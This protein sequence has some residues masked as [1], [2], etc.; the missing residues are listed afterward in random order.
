[1][2]TVRLRMSDK[3]Y[4]SAKGVGGDDNDPTHQALRS[5]SGMS[6]QGSRKQS[7]VRKPLPASDAA[8]RSDQ[9]SGD[10][11]VQTLYAALDHVDSG[12]LI[13][14]K[15]LRV[16]Y[17]NPALHETFGRDPNEINTKRP[18]YT[19]LLKRTAASLLVN[20]DDYVKRRLAWVRAADGTPMDLQMT[21]GKVVRAKVAL[22]PNG[23]RM[24]VYT[25]VTDIVRQAQELERLATTDGMT[26]IYNRR[27]FLTLADHEWNRARR[28]DRPV[29]F[30]MIDID[31]FKSVN[32]NFGHQVG[33]LMITHLANLAR[34]SKRDCD[35]LARI[36]GEEFALL[37]PETDL[38]QAQ[39]VAER[40]R[41]EVAANPLAAAS[42]SIPTTVS[43]GVAAAT[44]SM[45]DISDL[46]KA[47]DNALYEA[48][49][50]GRNRV[51][52]SLASHAA[53]SIAG[54]DD[55]PRPASRV[56]A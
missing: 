24:L 16:V 55:V 6:K 51:I 38:A 41:C 27:H 11:E 42:G 54:P 49:R 56:R 17:G 29:S 3:Q 23:G 21:N 5:G 1:M 13:L 9:A 12:L 47:A 35:V 50:A 53:P 44:A 19:E 15:E 39:I 20:V 8:A 7:S 18:L 40:L 32:D 34:E 10:E 14:S 46:M 36:G 22:L 2:A 48:K 33:D 26:G 37:L 30:L 45:K 28:Y 31:Y 25:D 52:C 43:I 4:A